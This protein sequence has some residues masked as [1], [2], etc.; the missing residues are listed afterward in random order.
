MVR[1]QERSRRSVSEPNAKLIAICQ[2]Q[3]K[4]YDRN[5]VKSQDAWRR[6]AIK[7]LNLKHGDLVVD[8]G[9]GTGLSFLWLQEVVG[10]QGTIIG[11]DLTDTLLEQ[12]RHRVVQ[13][14]WKN[15][16]LVQAD[17]AF[18]CVSRPGLWYS[19]DLCSHLSRY[20]ITTKVVRRHP[21]QIV[22]NTMQRCLVET[23]RLPVWMEFFYLAWGKKAAVFCLLARLS[24]NGEEVREYGTV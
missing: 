14:G 7:H 22:W 5:G 2:K 15:V 12:A 9:C 3:A 11:V 19:F 1:D 8:S 18:Y 13:A 17:A 16:E 20:G 21:W 4:T 24:N 23:R 6:S 10:P